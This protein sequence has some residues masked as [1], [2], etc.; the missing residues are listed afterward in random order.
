MRRGRRSEL[1]SCVSSTW[2]RLMRLTD[3]E[4]ER[5]RRIQ[6]RMNPFATRMRVRALASSGQTPNRV[7]TVR[8]RTLADKLDNILKKPKAKKRK[9]GDQ[10]E[11]RSLALSVATPLSSEHRI[12]P[13]PRRKNVSSC[14][15]T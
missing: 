9:K 6:T 13:S 7:S 2:H 11:V 1:C 12:S 15:P 10:E 5:R 3:S 4:S 14:E 8:R